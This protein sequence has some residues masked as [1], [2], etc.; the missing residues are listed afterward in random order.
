MRGKSFH[1]T[2]VKE[3]E[4]ILREISTDVHLEYRYR[5]NGLV[6]DFDLFAEEKLF[7]LAIEVETTSRHGIDNAE[8]AAAVNVPL[9][10]IVPTKKL[11]NKLSQQIRRLSLRA[12][13]EP[14][15]ILRLGQLRQ[16]LRNYLSL[17]IVANKQT[18]K[19]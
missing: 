4:N 18:D 17:F 1:N 9:W 2:I 15:K 6:T 14:I 16:E 7:T 12:G 10:I 8:K 5:R 19:K 13:G 11:K 3:A